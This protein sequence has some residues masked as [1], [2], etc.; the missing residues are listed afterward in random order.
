MCA[1]KAHAF[2]SRAL[3]FARSDSTCHSVLLPPPTWKH[4]FWAA[5]AILSSFSFSEKNLNI[6]HPNF[7]FTC[8]KFSSSF[9]FLSISGCFMPSE[10]SKKFSPKIFL[11]WA[12]GEARRDTMLPSIEFWRKNFKPFQCWWARLWSGWRCT[13]GSRRSCSYRASG[14]R[15]SPPPAPPRPQTGSWKQNKSA[16]QRRDS[17]ASRGHVAGTEQETT[18]NHRFMQDGWILCRKYIRS[19]CLPP[20]LPPS[21]PLSLSLSLFGNFKT[22]FIKTMDISG[23]HNLVK[24]GIVRLVFFH[25]RKKHQVVQTQTLRTSVPCSEKTCLKH[26]SAAQFPCGQGQLRV[27][28]P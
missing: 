2:V 16:Y 23:C 28:H 13:C 24:L 7:F 1:Q 6:F 10:C 4:D 22:N 15:R 5:L 20:S 11:Q 17:P 9:T 27:K 18:A 25:F 8:K 21:L 3:L 26:F 12:V 19:F 14:S